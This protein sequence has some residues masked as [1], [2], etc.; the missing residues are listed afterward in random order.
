[1]AKSLTV[2][3]E[4][5][6]IYLDLLKKSLTR[7]IFD[8]GYLNLHLRT[9]GKVKHALYNFIQKVLDPFDLELVKH[10]QFNP[11]LRRI[12]KD[13][14]A[15]AETM[16]GLYRLNNIQKCMVDVLSQNVAGDFIETGAWRGGAAIFMRGVLKA[17]DVMDR[18][19]WVADSFKGLPKPTGDKYK[20]DI[21][22]H[23]W[24]YDQLRVSLKDVK[25]NFLKYGLLDSQVKF[26]AGWFKDTLPSAPI[27]KLALLR[28]DGDMYESTMDALQALYPKLSRGGYVIVDDYCLPQA[29]EAVKDFRSQ[30]K[31]KDPVRRI[32]WAGVYWQRE[33]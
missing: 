6:E 2:N 8:E 17:Y 10:K 19:V 5:G 18:I 9:H 7:Y 12:G 30:M 32:D 13:W 25:A 20:Q 15:T 31:I 27:E 26:V 28:L 23:L 1:M 4:L 22:D 24:T 11:K 29:K 33:K 16:I 21:K 14:P 3:K